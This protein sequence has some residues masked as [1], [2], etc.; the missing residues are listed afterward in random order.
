MIQNHSVPSL[1]PYQQEGVGLLVRDIINYAKTLS[2]T[3]L[4]VEVSER[5]QEI[6]DL[7]SDISSNRP[8]EN[9]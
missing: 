1:R 8:S 7:Q 4:G 6:H 5:V 2:S 3:S 9:V